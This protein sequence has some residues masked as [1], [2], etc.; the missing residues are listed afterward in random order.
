[1][2]SAARVLVPTFCPPPMRRSCAACCATTPARACSFYTTQDPGELRQI[3]ARTTRLQ[4]EMWTVVRAPAAVAPTPITAL[5][6]ASI[7]DVLNAQGHTQS[8]WR[9]RIPIAAWVLM[10]A[11]AICANMLVWIGARSPQ[12]ESRLPQVLPLIVS[13]AFFLIADL[14]TPRRGAIHVVPQNLKDLMQSIRAT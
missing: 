6:V 7:N 8:A 1:M 14:D 11:I 10:L 12:F 2:R 5:A 4:A 13:I 3:N 9:N